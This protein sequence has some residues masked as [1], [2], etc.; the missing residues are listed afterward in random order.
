VTFSRRDVL[1][2]GA[3]LG[4]A[5]AAPALLRHAGAQEPVAAK[6]L[7]VVLNFGGWDT[8]YALD[9]KPG[10]TTI[11]APEGEVRRFGDLEIFDH[12]SRPE[13][14]TFFER[15]APIT[16]IV[17]GVQVRS[18]VHTDCVK[19]IL[20][21]SASETTP[22]IGAIAAYELGRSLPVP[23]LALGTQARSGP[24]ASITGR[25]GTTNQLSALV[26]PEQ[27]YANPRTF[28]P[29]PGLEATD[30]ESAF[31]RSYLEASA[32]RVQAIR[33]QHGYNRRRIEDFVGSLARAETLSRFARDGASLGERSYTP[34]LA[35]QVPLAVRAMKEGLSH[36]ALLEMTGWDTHQNNAQ[37]G[38]FNQ[39]LFGSL[40]M[41]LS[42]LEA[43]ALLD[44][45]MVLVLSEMGRTPKLNG[46][47]GKD[48][49]PV[50]SSM[51]IGA[52]VRGGRTFGG[53]NDELNALSVDLETGEVDATGS[54]LQ[55]ENLLAG[56]LESL[57]IDPEPHIPGADPFRAFQ[58]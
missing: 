28:R 26:D 56:I 3:A 39:A 5:L 52:G 45:T 35:A 29:D 46:D 51:L 36:T 15:W 21:G 20:T 6:H 58:S 12:P 33:G 7:M 50:T 9:P 14:A 32:G 27:A 13:V 18:F 23:Y 44:E 53:T 25:T 16:S 10:L 4:A 47:M 42:E 38:M 11:D 55:T 37:Q 48:H 57:G 2:T 31:V 22:D 30:E 43:N 1:K 19:R 17:H 34:Q 8:T 24:L 41:L 40:H 54:Q 49:W